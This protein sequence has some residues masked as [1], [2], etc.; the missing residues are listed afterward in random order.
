MKLV[1]TKQLWSK[2]RW[3]QKA[4][5]SN[6]TGCLCAWAARQTDLPSQPCTAIVD[7]PPPLGTTEEATRQTALVQLSAKTP[8]QGRAPANGARE[9]NGG[10]V[11]IWTR[12]TCTERVRQSDTQTGVS[13]GD[14]LYREASL[15]TCSLC[16]S[17]GDAVPAPRGCPASI[18]QPM[19]GREWGQQ[20]GECHQQSPRPFVPSRTRFSSS[21]YLSAYTVRVRLLPQSKRLISVNINILL[22]LQN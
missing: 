4:K 14:I 7:I 1:N 22:R 19:W 13:D 15:A 11:I 18:V 3:W 8:L 21:R 17:E 5:H 12:T 16:V 9:G 6:L 20:F 2:N 10:F